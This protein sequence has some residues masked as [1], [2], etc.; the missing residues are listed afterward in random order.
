[1]S[2]TLLGALARAR[3]LAN[4]LVLELQR[5]HAVSLSDAGPPEEP[6]PHPDPARASALVERWMAEDEDE[7]ERLRAENRR[8]LI[9]VDEAEKQ[10]KREI[11]GRVRAERELEQARR[12]LAAAHG[13]RT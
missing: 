4:S 1:M 3:V 6:E 2:T 5:L 13:G 9:E 12:E 7:L 10:W 8:L 11:D